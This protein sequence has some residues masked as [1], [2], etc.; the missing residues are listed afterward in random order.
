MKKYVKQKRGGKGDFMGH[1]KFTEW[2]N[3]LRESEL[4][5]KW[6]NTIECFCN[7]YKSSTSD[8]GDNSK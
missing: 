6:V 8:L 3:G 1:V 7:T 4:K 5:S 2:Y